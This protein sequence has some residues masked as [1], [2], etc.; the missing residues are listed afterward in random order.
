MSFLG[1]AAAGAAQ[2]LD[3]GN[4]HDI[5]GRSEGKAKRRAAS[6]RRASSA[7]RVSGP[8]SRSNS[9]SE[10]KPKADEVAD[11]GMA[12]PVYVEPGHDDDRLGIEGRHRSNMKK[13]YG[14]LVVVEAALKNHADLLDDLERTDQR[15]QISMRNAA[16]DEPF[17]TSASPYAI[18][19]RY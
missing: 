3:S 4:A 10:Q 13:I 6:A 1:S 14:Y 19:N 18:H 8:R 9:G 7:P 16:L 12:A 2:A 17:L 11:R 15:N 5:A